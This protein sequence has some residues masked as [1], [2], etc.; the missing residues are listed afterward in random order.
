LLSRC[1]AWTLAKGRANSTRGSGGCSKSRWYWPRVS[2]SCPAARWAGSSRVWEKTRWVVATRIRLSRT[3]AA[4]AIQKRR[5][6][7]MAGS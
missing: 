1:S 4:A 6:V 3:M 5:R 7:S 2:H